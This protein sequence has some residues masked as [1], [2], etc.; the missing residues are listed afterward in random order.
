MRRRMEPPENYW[1]EPACYVCDSHD[2]TQVSLENSTP[3]CEEHDTEVARRCADL[4][5]HIFNLQ[6]GQARLSEKLHR[7][8][9]DD[10]IERVRS[11]LRKGGEKLSE[12]KQQLRELQEQCDHEHV[13]VDERLHFEEHLAIIPEK[14]WPDRVPARS[15]SINCWECGLQDQWSPDW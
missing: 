8:Q 11:Q 6:E 7:G 3:L 1:P 5:Q 12:K 15:Y 9:D 14:E 13:D 2:V 10:T 4:E